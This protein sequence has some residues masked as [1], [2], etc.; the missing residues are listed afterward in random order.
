[1]NL[2]MMRPKYHFSCHT[3]DRLAKYG[4][5]PARLANWSEEDYIGGVGRTAQKTHK[6]DVLRSTL[7]RMY[8]GL[9]AQMS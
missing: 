4:L 5:N 7:E 3:V 8:Q 9:A 1:M 6:S 2:F